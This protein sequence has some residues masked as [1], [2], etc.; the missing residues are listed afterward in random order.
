MVLDKLGDSL[1]NTLGKIAKS[2]FVEG[3]WRHLEGAVR[4][5][6]SRS[7]VGMRRRDLVICMRGI[8]PQR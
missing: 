6:R 3:P 4:E 1:K 2:I 5:P 7:G 8:W